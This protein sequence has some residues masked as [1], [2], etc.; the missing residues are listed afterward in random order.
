V[1]VLAFIFAG[2]LCVHELRRVIRKSGP[3]LGRDRQTADF[4]S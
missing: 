3:R 1:S 2:L 4:V